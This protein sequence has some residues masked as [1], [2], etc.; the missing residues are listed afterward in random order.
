MLAQNHTRCL[1]P[2][3]QWNVQWKPVVGIGDRA[4]NGHRSLF[5]KK[6][7]AY[8]QCP[9]VASLFMTGLGIKIDFYDIALFYHTSFPAGSPQSTSS[10]VYSPLNP[11]NSS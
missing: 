5:I 4:H 10:G 9:P 3:I 11:S 8:D 7:I 2:A 1:R 6:I